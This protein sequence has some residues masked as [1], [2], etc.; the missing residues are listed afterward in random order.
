MDWIE[1]RFDVDGATAD[2]AS[3][4][5]V[6]LGFTD[7][8][9]STRL[10]GRVD[11]VAYGAD[12][13]PTLAV[14]VFADLGVAVTDQI[15]HDENE[16]YARYHPDSPVE[17]TDGVW[18]I[19]KPDQVDRGAD[20][21]LM[22]PPGP[23]WGDGRHP[24]TRMCAQ[25]VMRRDFS[26]QHVLDLG[27]GTGLLGILAHKRGATHVD[28]T[29]LDP[30]TLRVTAACCAANKV[31]ASIHA[32]DL[33]L[34]VPDGATYD[35]MIA[36]LWADLVLELL[37]DPRLHEVLPTGPLIAS[38]VHARRKDEVAAALTVAGFRVIWDA[39]DAWWWA[40]EAVQGE[41]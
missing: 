25:R 41:A 23:A 19:T 36:N 26:S 1:C 5:L 12:Q 11:V 39:E 40:F 35:V 27:C 20:V 33:L 14:Q 3:E 24:T 10:D 6:A 34:A 7:F 13:V 8:V 2:E 31:P 21:V 38:G 22:L 15:T 18:V 28:Y 17:L 4:Q 32:G 30:H 37:A 29:D 16:L 9:Q